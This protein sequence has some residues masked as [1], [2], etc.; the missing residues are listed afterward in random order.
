MDQAMLDVTGI[1]GVH[2]GDIATVFGHDGDAFLS[3]D[4][5]ADQVHTIHYELAC[6][7]SRRV[8]RVYYR[9]GELVHVT[10]YLGE[11]SQ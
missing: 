3:L 8:P 4:E 10:D 6:L 9:G 5:L 11:L 7:I 2:P 1:E